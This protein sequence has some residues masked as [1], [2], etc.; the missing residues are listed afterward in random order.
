VSAIRSVL[1]FP[2]VICFAAALSC[3]R[4]TQT[5]IDRAK[6]YYNEGK[7]EESTLNSRKALQ[8]DSRS[9]QA[10]YWLGLAESKLGHARNAYDALTRSV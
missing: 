9:G 3:G 1:V 4:S 2:L 7:Y 8:S 5:Y 6:G 10:Y